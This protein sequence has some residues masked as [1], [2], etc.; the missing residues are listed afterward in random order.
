[1]LCCIHT[2]KLNKET[3]P[4]KHAMIFGLLLMG[5]Q[6]PPV[7][8]NQAA[9]LEPVVAR[10]PL[11]V[12]YQLN[13]QS[14][15]IANGKHEKQAAPGSA[16]MVRTSVW[17]APKYDDLDDDGDDD[18][19][20]MLTQDSG[21]SGT[22]YYIAAAIQDDNEYTGTNAVLLGDRIAPQDVRIHNGVVAASFADRFPGES[23]AVLPSLVRTQY[24]T[25]RNG[26]LQPVDLP[27]DSTT[28]W[29]GW[30]T[31][32][33]EVR[34]FEPCGRDI[35]LWIEG[36]SSAMQEIIQ[37]HR[38]ALPN[39]A[40]YMP[41][42]MTLVGKEVEPLLTGFGAVY[43]GSFYATQLV[44]VTPQGYC[45]TDQVELTVPQPWSRVQTPMRAYGK[46]RGN[47]FFEGDTRIVLTES[48]GFPIMMSYVT[49]MGDWMT[50]DFVTFDGHIEFT[51]PDSGTWG[52]F[53]LEKD[54][55]SEN[56]SLDAK[57]KIPVLF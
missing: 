54:N 14:V 4:L 16:S 21:G 17:G 42:F 11:N 19:V 10:D 9:Q 24:L 31:I 8:D 35:P 52:W 12:E 33:H 57:V 26:T 20:V 34:T 15:Q 30:V 44:R 2:I 5:C 51:Q 6:Q 53:I 39:R 38:D 45:H 47:W 27:D 13:G 22:F 55:P 32:G 36:N 7:P 23:M 56:R 25:L 28:V 3:M 48:R 46:A 50:K 1:M 37:A 40:A 29:E 49:A 18:A 41:Y 43:S